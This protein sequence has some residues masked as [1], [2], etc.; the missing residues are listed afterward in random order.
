MSYYDLGDYYRGVKKDQTS[1]SGHWSRMAVGITINGELEGKQVYIYAKWGSV[2]ATPDSKNP[3]LGLPILIK[4]GIAPVTVEH[5]FTYYGSYNWESGC[6][7]LITTRPINDINVT[8]DDWMY[9][10]YS[11][12]YDDYICP[13]CT[14]YRVG[15]VIYLNSGTK[16][17]SS[18]DSCHHSDYITYQINGVKYANKNVD[19]NHSG[20]TSIK[21][22]IPPGDNIITYDHTTEGT[23]YRL[24]MTGQ[25]GKQVYNPL[26]SS[27]ISIKMNNEWK[28]GTGYIKADGQ[29]KS[30]KSVYIKVNDV[31]KLT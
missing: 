18:S 3:D 5:K 22:T 19:H 21:C 27:N 1:V 28:S 20:S 24:Y 17:T 2:P 6:N 15:D 16:C 11:S 30:I 8:G 25:S 31:W 7:L 9:I 26:S 13:K 29:W 10:P 12:S 14:E 23:K 4:S